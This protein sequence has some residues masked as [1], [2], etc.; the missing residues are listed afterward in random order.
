MMIKQNQ[1][2]TDYSV[3][4]KEATKLSFKVSQLLDDAMPNNIMGMIASAQETNNSIV[5]YN[6]WELQPVA[7]NNYTIFD[8]YS[9]EPIYQHI[10]LFVSALHIIWHLYKS[11][12]KLRSNEKLIYQTDQEYYRC[13]ENI[14]F[15]KKKSATVN[16]EDLPI[17]LA[18]LEDSRLRL[19]E[20][21]SILSKIY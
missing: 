10:S 14:K 5:F 16:S 15:Y 21:K 6:R 20:I 13:V 4:K 3:D 18:R 9:K 12:K 7:K 17:F 8:R 1:S 19:K 2:F 11:S